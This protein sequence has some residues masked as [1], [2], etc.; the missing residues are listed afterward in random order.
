MRSLKIVYIMYEGSASTYAESYF[1]PLIQGLVEEGGSVLFIRVTEKIA[2]KT[3]TVEEKSEDF[4]LVNA[5]IGMFNFLQARQIR[6]LARSF[7]RKREGDNNLVI[8][9]GITTF[10]ICLVSGLLTRRRLNF[11]YDSDGLSADEAIEFRRSWRSLVLYVPARVMEACLLLQAELVLTR[12]SMTKAVLQRRMPLARNRHYVELNN[13]CDPAKYSA[14]TLKD[15]S[16]ARESLG[17]SDKD[18]VFVYLGSYGHQYE[19]EKMLSVFNKVEIS[20]FAK[21]LLVFVPA[22]DVSAVRRL[23]DRYNIRPDSCVIRNIGHDQTP[24]MLAAADFGFSLR[25]ESFS[26]KHVKPL[27]TREYLFSG[28]SVIY[29]KFTGDAAGLPRDIGFVLDG[30]EGQDL[31]ALQKWIQ[32]RMLNQEFFCNEAKSFASLNLSIDKDVAL[33]SGAIQNVLG[34]DHR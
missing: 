20:G 9:R 1:I 13:G 25:R 16:D 17:L 4:V 27:K 28:L 22:N 10:W 34:G 6:Q 29:S 26:M 23:V 2:S 11:V 31:I 32:E 14:L 21:K 18:A 30:T 33:L 12:S 8:A 15:K 19:F 3:I 7:L 24:F 5:P